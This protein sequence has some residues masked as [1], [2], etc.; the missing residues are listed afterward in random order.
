MIL[1]ILL[2][3]CKYTNAMEVSIWEKESFF[4]KQDVIIAGSG[5]NG[6]WS[7]IYLKEIRP[8]WNITI[9]DRGTIPTGASTRNAGFACFGSPGEIVTNLAEASA[10]DVWSLV[11]M[12]YKGL[13]TILRY[14]N[15][16]AIAYEQNGGYEIFTDRNDPVTEAI[17]SK[18]PELN[19]QLSI[20]TGE[21][22]VFRAASNQISAF[23]FN[24][25]SGMIFNPLEGQLHSG[26]L[27]A[28]MMKRV[29]EAGVQ[30]L[31]G[32]E[33]KSWAH[34][35]QHL[36]LQTSNGLTLETD[37]LLICT[38]AFSAEL[39]PE[40]DVVPARGQILVTDPIPDLRLKGCFHFDA[41]YYYLRN[42]SNN[43]L[44]IGGARNTAIEAE[45]TSEMGITVGIQHHLESLLTEKILPATPFTVTDR[46]S[47]I[48]GMGHEKTPIIRPIDNNVFCCVRMS[49]MGVALAPEAAKEAVELLLA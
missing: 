34:Q 4:K 15:A 32:V 44:L 48:M 37:R 35:Q 18:L 1:F 8:H 3:C 7:A 30:I 12:R 47:G 36:M 41:G 19:H 10:D 6:L 39:I 24:G 46:W 16:D 42:L 22:E 23:G 11:E 14:F 29:Q 31:M 45:T 20:I 43:R 38:N 9:I 28:L 49:G 5:L 25:I 17:F 13:Q 33:L 26:K 21:E 27:V 40:L 2:D